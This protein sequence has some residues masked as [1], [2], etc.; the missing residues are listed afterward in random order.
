MSSFDVYVIGSGSAIPGPERGASSQLVRYAGMHILIDCAEGTQQRMQQFHLNAMRINHVLIS[1]LHGDHYFGLIGMIQSMHLL[2][3]VKPLQVFGPP[4]LI[5]ILRLQ[6]ETSDTR[7]RY[8][9]LFFPLE[10]GGKQLI[11]ENRQLRFYS[12]PLKHRIPTWGFLIQERTVEANLRPEFVE[13]Y[14]P[15]PEMMRL[16]K[17]GAG[18]QI[19]GG[20]FLP[21]EQITIQPRAPR[22]YVYCTDTIY[23]EEIVAHIAKADLLYHE[24]TFASDLLEEAAQTYH[25]TASQAAAI[26]KLADVKQLLIGHFSARYKDVGQLEAEAK[27]IFPNSLAV[28]DGERYS[29]T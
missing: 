16:I 11:F 24:A 27:E 29:I 22:S 23:D 17:R 8:P 18:Y 3:R 9:L 20:S 5:D 21:H 14:K 19:P 28:K 12:F 4:R 13:A 25:S 6:L 1:H 26:A 7:L 2:G 10:R 15:V